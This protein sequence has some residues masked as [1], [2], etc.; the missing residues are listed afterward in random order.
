MT[1]A[2]LAIGCGQTERT[3]NETTEQAQSG[4][5]PSQLGLSQ[6]EAQQI[7][8]AV[9]SILLARSFEPGGPGRYPC[10]SVFE[11]GDPQIVDANLSERTGLI[12]VSIPVIGR[13][14]FVFPVR[15]SPQSILPFAQCFGVQDRD[16]VEA[17][18]T[19]PV[20]IQY[21]V[22]KWATGWRLSANQR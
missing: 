8:S 18:I 15:A 22:E 20:Q 12:V 11:I 7:T 10:T 4:T 16:G 21:S 13:R 1:L 19:F 5:A 3:S 2:F 17:G 14:P 9:K 6:A